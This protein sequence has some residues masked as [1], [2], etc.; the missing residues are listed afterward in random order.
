MFTS[1]KDHA[2]AWTGAN[3]VEH[4]QDMGRERGGGLHLSVRGWYHSSSFL[5][6]SPL[7][8][9]LAEL[10]GDGGVAT[11]VVA[12]PLLRLDPRSA[13][14][15][16][17]AYPSLGLRLDGRRRLPRT[18]LLERA[19]APPNAFAQNP[20]RMPGDG[21]AIF[22]REFGE[23]LPHFLGEFDGDHRHMVPPVW[24]ARHKRSG[25]YADIKRTLNRCDDFLGVSQVLH[26]TFLIGL[27]GASCQP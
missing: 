23:L 10:Q 5:E 18:P 2:T 11:G 3:G 17:R 1:R 9:R 27:Y 22:G 14:H 25:P 4:L 19:I 13:P 16:L 24:S 26:I 20:V 8:G 21:A 7:G 6:A 15:L 12:A